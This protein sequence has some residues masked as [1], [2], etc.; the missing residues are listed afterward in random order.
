MK[1]KRPDPCPR[2]YYRNNAGARIFAL[3]PDTSKE[4]PIPKPADTAPNL[5]QV[6]NSQRPQQN[7]KDN[8]K[9]RRTEQIL[10]L[11]AQRCLCAI[12][13][14]RGVEQ[15]WSVE[16]CLLKPA[17]LATC[18]RKVESD[19]TSAPKLKVPCSSATT[20]QTIRYAP[21]NHGL[22][23]VPGHHLLRSRLCL[24]A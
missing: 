23:A 24:R 19:P 16:V 13:W 6:K 2:N 9:I 22:V 8:K 10:F 5:N 7:G 14:N 20:R 3:A 4:R 11:P 17:I 15:F 12:A 21:E 18:R 1:T